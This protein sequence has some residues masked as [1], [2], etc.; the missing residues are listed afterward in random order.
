[1]LT[2]D[3]MSTFYSIIKITNF[4]KLKF[5]FLLNLQTIKKMSWEKVQSFIFKNVGI[6]SLLKNTKK[7][8]IY[9]YIDIKYGY[10]WVA[11]TIHNNSNQQFFNK[12]TRN[13]QVHA[14]RKNRLPTRQIRTV[15]YVLQKLRSHSYKMGHFNFSFLHEQAT[16]TLFISASPIPKKKKKKT[17]PNP[18]G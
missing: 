3:E 14:L 16:R 5:D 4:I 6:Y 15:P 11:Q 7:L 12:N 18:F 17:H 2:R 1:L 13:K 8:V 9:S 10:M